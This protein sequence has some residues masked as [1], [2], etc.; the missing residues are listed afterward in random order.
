MK[1]ISIRYPSDQTVE[2]FDFSSIAAEQ[3]LA[4]GDFDGVHLGHREV[5]G[6]AVQL[7]ESLGVL[8]AIMTFDPHPREVLGQQKYEFLLTPFVHRKQLLAELNVDILYIV[9]FNVQFASLTAAQFIEEVLNRMKLRAVVIGFD[10]TFG[11]RG[12]GNAEYLKA[13]ANQSFA[14]HITEPHLFDGQK[15]SS[16]RIR[17]H[18]ADGSVTDIPPLLGRPYDLIGKV[19]YGD[20]RGRQLGFPTANLTLDGSYILPTLGVYAVHAD[21]NGERHIGVVNIGVR[22]TFRVDPPTTNIEVHLLDFDGDLYGSTMKIELLHFL[23]AEKKFASVE[24]LVAQ[25]REDISTTRR[26]LRLLQ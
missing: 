4:I 7:A 15:V 11:H 12:L 22:P 2:S 25:I 3:V 19:D 8:S 9:E 23:R 17:K 18:L 24:Q 6:Q 13:Y 20:G 14:V 21:V 1:V 16:T 10:F 5:I 26:L